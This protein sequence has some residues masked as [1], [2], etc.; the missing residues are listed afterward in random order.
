[1]HKSKSGKPHTSENR[2]FLNSG[3]QNKGN[4]SVKNTLPLK[5][6][7]FL[8]GWLSSFSLRIENFDYLLLRGFLYATHNRSFFRYI[9]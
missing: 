1:M 6:E 3:H 8:F 5:I 7:E 2:R 9:S 4:G